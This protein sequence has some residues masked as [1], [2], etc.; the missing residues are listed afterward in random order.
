MTRDELVGHIGDTARSLGSERAF[1]ILRHRFKAADD[2]DLLITALM[3]L[4]DQKKCVGAR[5]TEVDTLI[6]ELFI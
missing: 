1:I 5:E 3:R 4:H 6:P 2:G